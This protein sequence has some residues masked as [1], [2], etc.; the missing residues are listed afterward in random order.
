MPWVVEVNGKGE[1]TASVSLLEGD[2]SLVDTTT[3]WAISEYIEDAFHVDTQFPAEQTLLAKVYAMSTGQAYDAL[4][5]YYHA[6]GGVNNPLTA[7]GKYWSAVKAVRTLKLSTK[8]SYQV[9]YAVF[10][11]DH[12]D[13]EIDPIRTNWRATLHLVHGRPTNNNALGLYVDAM[14][15]QPEEA[16]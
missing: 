12:H 2:E 3:R 10:R 14:D 9:D 1:P 8:D 13:H 16:K 6:D 7:N 11:F 4:T 15:F 5:A